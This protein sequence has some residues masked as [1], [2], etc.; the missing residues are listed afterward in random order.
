MET[1]DVNLVPKMSMLIW[2]IRLLR[3]VWKFSL[4]IMECTV[5]ETAVIGLLWPTSQ[6]G[7]GQHAVGDGS[8]LLA[9]VT[10]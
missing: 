8:L 9:V 2:F 3:K 4:F 10:Y 7:K 5:P 1:A 6:P